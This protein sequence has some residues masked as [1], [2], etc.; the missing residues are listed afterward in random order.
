MLLRATDRRAG[1]RIT[2][3]LLAGAAAVTGLQLSQGAQ[4]MVG[5]A[6]PAPAEY[7]HSVVMILGS[8]GTACTATAIGRDLLLTAAHCVQP[9]AD[10][11]L[12]GSEPG[13]PPVLKT[14][15]RI[16]RHPQFD[17]KRLFNHLATADVALIKLAQPLPAR[18][19]PAPIAG[20]SETVAVGDSLVV[21]G[22]GV[23]LRGDGR[24][25]GTARATTLVV[26]GQPGPLQVRLFDPVSKGLSA[27]L[28]A[29]A[30]DSGA[31]AFRPSSAGPAILGVVSWSTGPNLT[32]GCG[33]LTGVTPLARYRGW[34][35]DTA[36]RLGTPLT[37]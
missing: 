2:A 5:G 34:I 4:A 27:G 16:E 36:R 15:I 24:T 21:A 26:T 22:Y 13:Q 29:C 9:G 28:G 31:P 19:S 30:G 7:G 25:G 8:S 11:K 3:L 23:T 35:V 6:P 17:I 33:G 1:K 32:A 12:L 18:I 14:I 37:P 20:G 10:Y